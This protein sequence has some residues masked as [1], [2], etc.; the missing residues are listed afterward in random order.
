MKKIIL[1]V[2]LLFL[3]SSLYACK[4]SDLELSD[5]AE[6]YVEASHE[7]DLTEK[8]FYGFIGAVDG[9][10]FYIDN[11]K[12]AIYEFKTEKDLKNSGFTFDAINGRFALESDSATAIEIFNNLKP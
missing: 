5:F 12:V 11:K 2:V 1:L 8:P 6:A 3:V 4:S 9:F 10:I 7:V